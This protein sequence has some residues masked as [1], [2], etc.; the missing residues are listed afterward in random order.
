VTATAVNVHGER[1]LKI[2]EGPRSLPGIAEV[3][4]EGGIGE[5]GGGLKSLIEKER[6]STQGRKSPQPPRFHSQVL[7]L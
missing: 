1:K 2:S 6:K 7:S 3:W 5:A 4:N